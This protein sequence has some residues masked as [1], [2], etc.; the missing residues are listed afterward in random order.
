MFVHKSVVNVNGF[1]AKGFKATGR[2]GLFFIATDST[3]TISEGSIIEGNTALATGSNLI[4]VANRATLNIANATIRNNTAPYSNLIVIS[5]GG[6]GKVS[7][8]TMIKNN[9][10]VI[11][12]SGGTLETEYMT[13]NQKEF[14]PDKENIVFTE[15]YGRHVIGYDVTKKGTVLKLYGGKI[16][17]NSTYAVFDGYYEQHKD[18][19]LDK[20][21]HVTVELV[22]AS[23]SEITLILIAEEQ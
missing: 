13:A 3:L 1:V 12:V 15:N 16:A 9:E 21:T 8:G 20:D 11:Y 18:K 7:R 10:N 17:T 2:G 19:I 23:S 22:E 6:Y 14:I 4:E 5:E